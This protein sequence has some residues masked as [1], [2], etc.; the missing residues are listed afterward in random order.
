MADF[1]NLDKFSLLEH[2]DSFEKNWWHL[3]SQ[4]FPAYEV[5]WH[6]YVVPL[7]NRIDRGVA[8]DS[9][10]SI[11]T[12]VGV[13]PRYEKMAMAHYSVFYYLARATQMTSDGEIY[14]EDPFYLLDS[15]ADNIHLFFCSM[16][17]II[18]DLGGA[19]PALPKQHPK[20]YP[21]AFK[22]IQAYRDA[23]L[24]NPV[25]GRLTKDGAAFLPGENHL[26]Q[27]KWSW[28][29]LASLPM[30][31]F[32]NARD[33]LRN[34]R[35]EV[36]GYVQTKWGE[37]IETMDSVRDSAKFRKVLNLERF[38]PIHVPPSVMT[39]VVGPFTSSSTTQIIAA[40]DKILPADTDR[41]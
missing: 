8:A 19:M 17:E 34:V 32:V 40:R 38:L 12:R 3:L 23:M 30:G 18:K 33:L 35:V 29:K 39:C 14:L 27:I 11:K 24:H 36:A 9:P 2:G 15:C 13:S 31:D 6:R 21:P 16:R 22:T 37:I 7:T 10:E 28:R 4:D 41:D 25:L 5:F 1:E 20:D 26:K